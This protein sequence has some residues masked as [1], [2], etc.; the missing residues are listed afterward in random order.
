MFAKYTLIYM[1]L[2]ILPLAGY[3]H[4]TLTNPEGGETFDPGKEVTI[5]WEISID[6]GPCVWEVHFSSDEGKTWD[7]L[8]T[9]I[10]KSTLSYTWSIPDV[11]TEKARIRV[12]QKNSGY[13]NFTD[14]SSNFTIGDASDNTGDGMSDDMSGDTNTITG[15]QTVQQKAFILTSIHPNPFRNSL[16]ITFDLKASAHVTI[17]IYNIQGRKITMLTDRKLEAGNHQIGW[18]ATNIPEGIYLCRIESG[19]HVTTRRLVHSK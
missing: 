4:V 9:E 8:A 3:S 6:H 16:Q 15:I 14:E 17:T 13:T 12:V 11:Q 7:T 1:L 2:T 10:E 5:E 19:N 18:D